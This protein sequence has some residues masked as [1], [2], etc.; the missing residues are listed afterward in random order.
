ME[1]SVAEGRETHLGALGVGA[2]KGPRWRQ[3]EGCTLESCM[4]VMSEF[5]LTG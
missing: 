4:K 1:R 2:R 3:T 5:W